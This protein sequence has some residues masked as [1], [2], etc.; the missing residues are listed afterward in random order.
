ML[1]VKGERGV[2]KS[3]IIK[4]IQLGFSFLKRRKELLIAALIGTAA[5]NIGSA[6]IHG[7]LSIDDCI[8]KQHRLAK[9]PGQT[10]LALILDEISMVSLKLLLIVDIHL[11]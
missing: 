8:Q 10:R 2:G 9:G 4:A 11:S 6:T 1:Y 3:R 7:A 5:A